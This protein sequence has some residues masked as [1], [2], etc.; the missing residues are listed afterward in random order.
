VLAPDK[1]VVRH[2]VGRALGP[3]P[4]W[5]P[6]RGRLG[7]LL[8]GRSESPDVSFEV[9]QNPPIP[10][11]D[12]GSAPAQRQSSVPA[13]IWLSPWTSCESAD[14]MRQRFRS[15]ELPRPATYASSI[16]STNREATVGDICVQI[17]PGLLGPSVPTLSAGREMRNLRASAILSTSSTIESL[18]CCVG[19]CQYRSRERLPCRR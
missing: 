1:A 12:I 14:R 11:R 7:R 17:P 5:E 3:R 18:R 19:P 15:R 13:A 10:L 8:P 9:R 16:T 6:W 2:R 4:L